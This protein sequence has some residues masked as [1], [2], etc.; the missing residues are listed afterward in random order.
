L[1]LFS[2]AVS[3]SDDIGFVAV[4]AQSGVGNSFTFEGNAH[5]IV[6]DPQHKVSALLKAAFARLNTEFFAQY[7]G[8]Y[9]MTQPALC[10]L[11][12]DLEVKWAWTYTQLGSE[13]PWMRVLPSVLIDAMLAGKISGTWKAPVEDFHSRNERSGVS[14]SKTFL[15]IAAPAPAPAPEP[16]EAT[17][18]KDDGATVS[19]SSPTFSITDGSAG[20]CIVT[21]DLPL[22]EG[23]GGCTLDV[24]GANKLL[25]AAP[26]LYE[27][28]AELP[29]AVVPSSAA[30]KF[31]KKRRQL[32]V[33]LTK[34]Q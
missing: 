13:N 5:P 30:A 19:V 9:N 14:F 16:E 7:N 33:T 12:P 28:E 25:F 23:Y 21:I 2:R 1:G 6:E 8:Q 27:L 18:E 11:G 26:A 31:S 20:E 22:L 15:E 24:S 32:T 29:C 17:A 10:V 4:T 34:E 3:Q